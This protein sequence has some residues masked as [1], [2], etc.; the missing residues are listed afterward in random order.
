[1]R[2]FTLVEMMVV[3]LVIS[4][5][6]GIAFTSYQR[7]VIETRR[8]T[9]TACLVELAQFMERY[10]TTNLTYVGAAAPALQCRT[11]LS[12]FYTIAIAGTPTAT[13]Y[14]LTA[15]PVG[16]QASKDTRCGT[17]GM[18]QTGA[19]SATGAGGVAECW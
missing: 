9:A 15:T 18:T 12:P 7:N 1:M 8:R 2:G 4:I 17:L 19:K 6:S 16:V 3:V 11:D 5:L 14:S 10:Y 13:A